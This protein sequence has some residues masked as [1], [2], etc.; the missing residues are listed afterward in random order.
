M[1]YV[2]AS[3]LVMAISPLIAKLALDDRSIYV[4]IAFYSFGALI[5]SEFMRKV[6]DRNAAVIARPMQKLTAREFVVGIINGFGLALLFHALNMMHPTACSF[7]SRTYPLFCSLLGVIILK[8]RL[9][10]KN[11][12]IILGMIAGSMLFSWNPAGLSSM[13]GAAVAVGY[14]L[15]FALANTIGA[16]H[17]K[18]QDYAKFVSKT[19]WVTFVFTSLFSVLWLSCVGGMADVG[20]IPAVMLA[21]ALNGG[22]GMML[23]YCGVQR[24]GFAQANAIRA[25]SPLVS[26]VVTMP[27]FPI[28]WT[29]MQGLGGAILMSGAF[30]LSKPR[31]ASNERVRWGEI[32]EFFH[33]VLV[34]VQTTKGVVLVKNRNRAWEFPGGTREPDETLEDTAIREAYEEAGMRITSPATKGFYRLSSGEVTVVVHAFLAGIEAI[35]TGF[36]T[37]ERG[38]FHRLPEEKSFCDGVMEEIFDRLAVHC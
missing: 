37:I 7:L 14:S 1:I 13:H 27:F 17:A 32:P 8:E 29:L 22:V 25:A 21:G 36:E 33:S 34:F 26:A 10:L 19:N 31:T 5:A 28:Q 6:N 24:M 35:P 3:M 11:Q 9:G 2:V 16:F 4:L 38:F 23:Y 15:L 12:L 18:S 30:L 20:A